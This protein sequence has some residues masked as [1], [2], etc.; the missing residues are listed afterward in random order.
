MGTQYSLKN[1]FVFV[2]ERFG[3]KGD[4]SKSKQSVGFCA[5]H[6]IIVCSLR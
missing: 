6:D 1:V 3:A 4:R 5:A 2:I